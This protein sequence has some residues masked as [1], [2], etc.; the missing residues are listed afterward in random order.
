MSDIVLKFFYPATARLVLKQAEGQTMDQVKV[1]EAAVLEELKAWPA[2]KKGDK[3][4]E[5]FKRDNKEIASNVFAL[6]GIA[7]TQAD[8]IDFLKQVDPVKSDIFAELMSPDVRTGT[9]GPDL[10]E[11]DRLPRASTPP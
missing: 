4:V 1:V 8:I 11:M 3:P 9:H 6:L 10:V 7:P 5:L 2:S